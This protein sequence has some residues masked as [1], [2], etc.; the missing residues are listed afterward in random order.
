M[1]EHVSDPQEDAGTGRLDRAPILIVTRFSYLG[2]SGWKSDASRDAEL[3]FDP[4]RLASRFALFHA[5]TLPSLAG[6]TDP[7]FHHLILTSESLPGDMM[8]MLQDACAAAYGDPSRYTV[9]ARPPGPARREL[10]RFMA[11]NM[12]GGPVVQVV[13]DDDDGLSTDFVAGLRDDLTGLEAD[14]PGLRQELPYFISYP[15]GYGLSLRNGEDAEIFAHSFPY[16]NLGLT[17]IGTPNGKN[18]FA[19]A[20]RS[21]PQRYGVRLVEGRR[22][23]MRCIHDFNDSRVAAHKNWRR[24]EDW[25][26]D[27][28]LRSRFG[29][30]LDEGAPWAGPDGAGFA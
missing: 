22:A 16:I 29:Y 25:R 4:V 20:H 12:P 11:A 1:A 30:V 15:Q 19:I 18:I 24:I 28:D 26:E 3:L 5:V 9:Y 23:F 2:K 14:M 7:G 6:Q 13:V 27:E 8:G 10:R 17:M 21:S